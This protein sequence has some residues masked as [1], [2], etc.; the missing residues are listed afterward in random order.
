MIF[1]IKIFLQTVLVVVAILYLIE[2]IS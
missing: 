1:W 2:H